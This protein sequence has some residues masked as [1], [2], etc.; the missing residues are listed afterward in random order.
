MKYKKK[1]NLFEEYFYKYKINITKKEIQQLFFFLENNKNR[2]E[3]ETTYNQINILNLPLL[4]D[5]KDQIIFILEKHN[6]FISNSWAQLYKKGDKH[7]IHNHGGSV[8]SGVLYVNGRGK[9]GTAFHHPMSKM[10]ESFHKNFKTIVMTKFEPGVLILFPS[11]IPHE[12][13]EQKEENNRLIISFNTK[14]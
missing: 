1:Y 12:V 13:V 7:R 2:E 14:I 9:D 8:Y 5:I 3:Q 6:L 11:Y 4:K 10:I